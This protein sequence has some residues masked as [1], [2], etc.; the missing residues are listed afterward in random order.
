MR[1]DMG[2]A[3]CVVATVMALAQLGCRQSVVGL[4]PLCE[5]MPSSC[6]V[7]PGDV[8]VAKNGKSIEVSY[9]R[10]TGKSCIGY[11]T[12]SIDVLLFQNVLP[13]E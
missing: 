8:V 4:V 11:N 2:G 12:H 5:N 10:S 3:A 1:A 7:K 6:A 13:T 9:E